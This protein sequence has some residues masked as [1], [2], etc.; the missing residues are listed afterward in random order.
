LIPTV[1]QFLEKIFSGH[2][3]ICCESAVRDFR[4]IVE[5]LGGDGEKARAKNLLENVINEIVPDGMSDRLKKNL[6]LSGKIK[7]R[8]R[9]IFGTGDLLQVFEFQL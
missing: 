8:S 7:E 3:L 1:K 6:Y 2:K 9:A 5:T 4:V